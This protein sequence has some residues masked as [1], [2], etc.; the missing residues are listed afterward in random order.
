MIGGS[1]CSINNTPLAGAFLHFE[2]CTLM[3]TQ[4]DISTTQTMGVFLHQ[5]QTFVY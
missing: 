5:S 4:T 2:I 1:R 3:F